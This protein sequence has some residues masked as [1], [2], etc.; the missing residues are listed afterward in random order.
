M[1]IWPGKEAHTSNLS[2]LESRD[3]KD[4]D[5]SPA[6]AESKISYQQM[7]QE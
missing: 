1:K 5:S 6:Q 2:Y 4:H 3:Y 7:N